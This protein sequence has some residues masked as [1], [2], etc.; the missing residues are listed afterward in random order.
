MKTRHELDRISVSKSNIALKSEL[1]EKG[2]NV[3]RKSKSTVIMVLWGDDKSAEELQREIDAQN[4]RIKQAQA[5]LAAKRQFEANIK[6]ECK[7]ERLQKVTIANLWRN[8]NRRPAAHINIKKNSFYFLTADDKKVRVSDHEC[9]HFQVES[10]KASFSRAADFE[11]PDFDFVIDEL[12]AMTRQQA[13][14][15]I[16]DAINTCDNNQ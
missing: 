12:E 11:A 6:A 16:K 5:D 7:A 15:F 3:L 14:A 8:F 13:V 2:Y 1:I 4:E 9:F 10:E